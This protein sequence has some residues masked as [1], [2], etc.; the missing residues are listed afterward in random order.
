MTNFDDVQKVAKENLDK[1][2]ASFTVLQQGAQSVVNEIAEYSKKAFESN[3]AM[4]ETLSSVKNFEKAIELQS[5]FAKTAYEGLVQHMT[6]IGTIATDSAK[7][8]YKPME[9]AFA[10]AK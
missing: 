6:K 9:A 7:E 4:I 1:Q 2:I 3:T 10:S 8:A 5:N